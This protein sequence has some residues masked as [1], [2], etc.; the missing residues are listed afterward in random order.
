MPKTPGLPFRS[1]TP[2][3]VALPETSQITGAPVGWFLK[4]TVTP[5]GM[6]MDEYLKT[7]AHWA[8]S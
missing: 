2:S 5:S 6:L 8:G 3:I 7:I 1:T 4:V